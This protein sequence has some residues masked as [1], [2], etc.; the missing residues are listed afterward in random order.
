MVCG[1]SLSFR[2]A[3]ANPA[4][5]HREIYFVLR[6]TFPIRL[7]PHAYEM[8]LRLIDFLT[9]GDGNMT[10]SRYSYVRHVHRIKCTAGE[11]WLGQ[12]GAAAAHRCQCV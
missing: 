1:G 10:S 2:D 9:D 4:L 12:R 11:S 5:P 7:A 8:L 3:A 6:I